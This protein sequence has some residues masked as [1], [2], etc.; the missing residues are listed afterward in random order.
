M[1]MTM[2][3][4]GSSSSSS[5]SAEMVEAASE[6]D[7]PPR[8]S[9]T[10]SG[11]R[12]FTPDTTENQPEDAAPRTRMQ[13]YVMRDS[14]SSSSNSSV[15]A[16]TGLDSW[17]G[18][19]EEDDDDDL[20]PPTAAF[21]AD[22]D[23]QPFARETCGGPPMLLRS[24]STSSS[25]SSSS[26][27]ARPEDVLVD[28]ALA[29]TVIG[30]AATRSPS[31]KVDGD[32]HQPFHRDN[33]QSSDGV[34]VAPAD[35][36][37][38]AAV[39]R[40]ISPSRIELREEQA[41]VEES[42]R[43]S[44]DHL[45]TG[46]GLDGAAGGA[47]PCGAVST[48]SYA[49]AQHGSA[50][51]AENAECRHQREEG[52]ASP[53]P[54]GQ[55][56]VAVH[57]SLSTSSAVLHAAAA[58]VESLQYRTGRAE[59]RHLLLQ[60]ERENAALRETVARQQSTIAALQDRVF[61]EKSSRE[62]Q[63]IRFTGERE[64]EQQDRREQFQQLMDQLRVVRRSAETV[65]RE[66]E[67][68]AEEAIRQKDNLTRLVEAERAEQQRIR[69]AYRRETEMMIAEQGREI[70]Y[71]RQLVERLRTDRDAITGALDLERGERAS[72]IFQL[73]NQVTALEREKAQH[74]GQ[75]QS[76]RAALQDAQERERA[77]VQSRQRI[78]DAAC[79]RLQHK[80]DQLNS[81]LS[82]L[83]EK[84]RA[85]EE[86]AEDRERA[87][88][89]AHSTERE[90]W[91][92]R[93]SLAVQQR[94]TEE[95]R[96][97]ADKLQLQ[98]R[99]AQLEATL[100]AEQAQRTSTA[101]ELQEAQD[102]TIRG[103]ESEMDGLRQ[104]IR[105]LAQLH[106]EEKQA[107][108]EAAEQSKAEA[109]EEL[110]RQLREASLAVESASKAAA[111][112]QERALRAEEE[113]ASEAGGLETSLGAVSQEREDLRGQLEAA[114]QQL[115]A[116]AA[117]RSEATQQWRREE[118][119]L[120]ERVRQLESEMDGLRQEIR[121]LAQLHAEEKQ[122]LAEAAEQSKAEAEEELR[123]QLR[124]ASLAVESASKAAAE[125]QERALRAEEEG[126]S[127]RRRRAEVHSELETSLGAVSQ[128]R[129]DLRGQLEAARQQL[130]AEAA[131][132]SEATQQWRREEQMLR[133]RVRQL[134][135]EMDGLRQEIRCL[136]QLH[137]EEKQALAEAAE[138]SKAE[139]E[140]ELRRQL[141]EASLAVES[142]SKAAAEAQE[143]ALRAEEE[144][145]SERRRRAEVH[146]ELETSL[147]AVSQ[148]R[149]DLRG[150]LEA[151]RQQLQAEAAARSEA[152]QQWRREEQ[153][154]RERVRQLESEMD[155]LRQEIRC[156][157]QLHAEEK[158]A[159]AEA[160]EQSKAEAEE[161][162]RR[163]LREASLAVES[164]S[165]AA[166][167]AQERALRAEEEG[168][169]ERRRRAE[170]HSELETSLGAV[171][172]E[173]ED[174]RG[175]LEA[176]RQQLQAEAAARSEAT[177]QW[178]REE[179]MLRERVRQLESE[180]DEQQLACAEVRQ[181]LGVLQRERDAL[182][183]SAWEAAAMLDRQRTEAGL[184]H[185]LLSQGWKWRCEIRETAISTQVEELRRQVQDSRAALWG[186][187]KELAM[188]RG[189]LQEITRERDAAVAAEE[190]ALE[191]LR[192][193]HD[194]ELQSLEKLLMEL[195]LDLSKSQTMAAQYL[196]EL[197]AVHKEK[198]QLRLQLEG[199]LDALEK[200]NE[201]LAQD[202]EYRKM[203]DTEL[204]GTL[205]MLH[206]RLANYENENRSLHEELLELTKKLQETHMLLGR[207][208]AAVNQLRA[209]LRA[210]ET[211]VVVV[212]HIAELNYWSGLGLRRVRQYPVH[213]F[214]TLS[215][216]F[217]SISLLFSFVF[218]FSSDV[219]L[220]PKFGFAD[221]S[222]AVIIIVRCI[223]Y[224]CSFC[225]GAYYSAAL[226]TQT[227]NPLTVT[228]SHILRIL[229]G[230]PI[231]RR[232]ATHDAIS[233]YQEAPNELGTPPSVCSDGVKQCS[234]I[235]I[236]G[237]GLLATMVL[238]DLGPASTKSCDYDHLGEDEYLIA[239]PPV[240]EKHW[241]YSFLSFYYGKGAYM[242]T[243]LLLQACKNC[244]QCAICIEKNTDCHSF[245]LQASLSE[246]VSAL[247]VNLSFI[248][249]PCPL[250]VLSVL[251]YYLFI[252]LSVFS[253]CYRRK[254]KRHIHHLH[255]VELPLPHT[256]ASS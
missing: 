89:A 170:V 67:A 193:Q 216:F 240:P 219:F 71:L 143:R 118:Q 238:T 244:A 166:A 176:A 232:Q 42:G 135:S 111:E 225:V 61:Q 119:M 165:K 169:S 178:R 190:Q 205:K 15:A 191:Q 175:Q 221:L 16:P 107:L 214:L 115:Q 222:L 76:L 24:S 23:L 57:S 58:L 187:E 6:S 151:A 54:P 108:A 198:E 77:A 99:I 224:V 120:R 84:L 55:E 163:Q 246:E 87:L 78:E 68:L 164:A 254:R 122:A 38:T 201:A 66:K 252:Y 45:A 41:A 112:A 172:Q 106:A 1:L 220:S 9:G 11:G 223:F 17:R 129:E 48:P 80:V 236:M 5:S 124:E 30:V 44:A 100:A 73:Q 69:E 207:K 12:V 101:T 251:Y 127:E 249:H 227:S 189:T 188:C 181:R 250:S 94:E 126:A 235:P 161:E 200:H 82:A 256:R 247:A 96:A 239:A 43:S 159:L 92:G 117:A 155:G 139:A 233:N 241:W 152:T 49:A 10:L 110:R 138:Q 204:Q 202:L 206:S 132:R 158:Q 153:M 85:A 72:A 103:M 167:E 128:E 149:E 14:S 147:G 52:E 31:N 213:L 60:I 217:L 137:A 2:T 230:R 141:R 63:E 177:Q 123:R 231:E 171:S 194:E 144:G 199:D 212:S 3:H 36:P 4:S 157:A 74:A 13:A 70:T 33:S 22:D 91:E 186:R 28:A 34:G 162:L 150:Q 136:A 20:A 59:L 228:T 113:G 21:E 145:A 90:Q 211:R 255:V 88:R 79:E 184:L 245:S 142:A 248:F 133:E 50:E 130:Q 105:C 114:R 53:T 146:S 56:N 37:F 83:R 192:V 62:E 46:D 180:M 116:E 98:Q 209:Q 86:Q 64:R 65:L 134:E 47:S 35:A 7:P 18:E 125:A 109:E 81:Q 93:L 140:E 19:E 168:A 8:R 160:A 203:L 131:A 97:V 29:A 39:R 234:T 237:A 210:F 197:T 32:A 40:A 102:R 208:D 196:R 27:L 121:C 253:R 75:L 195:R 185:Q 182:E 179:Q 95:G 226:S 243:L 51:G 156:L 154:L 173:R 25:T 215:S 218:G 104:E 26:G 174:L 242:A 229:T 148:E 183:L